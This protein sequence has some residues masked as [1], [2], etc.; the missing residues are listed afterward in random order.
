[1]PSETKSNSRPRISLVTAWVVFC[2]FCNVLGWVLSALHELNAGG[3]AVAFGLGLVAFAGWKWKTN[4]VFFRPNDFAKS[5]RRFRRPFPMAF[6]ILAALAIL[7]GVIYAP[8]NYD[9][10]AYRLPRVLHWLAEGHWHWIHTDFE[11]VNRRG[12]GIEWVCA[13][14]MALF[15]TDRP[16][17]LLN[18]ISFLLLPG[19]IF[20][21][22]TKLG[23]R[24]RTAWYW[25]WPLSCGY[26]FLLQ[27]GSIGNDLFTVP[28]VLAAMDYA[29]RSHQQKSLRALWLSIVAAALFTGVKANTVPL[30]LPWVIALA[31][32]WKMWWRKAYVTIPVC[33]VALVISFAPIGYF[34]AKYTGDWTGGVSEHLPSN[35]SS[36]P[37]KLAG[38]CVVLAING[39]TPPIAPFASW[40]NGHVAAKLEKTSLGKTI[41]E[42]FLVGN[43]FMMNEMDTEEVAGFGFGTYLLIAV[44]A[45]AV[46]LN[47]RN[48]AGVKMPRPTVF[49][50]VGTSISFL[51][52]M[53]TSFALSTPRLLAPYYLLLIFPLVFLADTGLLHKRWWKIVVLV[54]FALAALPLIAS[55]ARPLFPWRPALVLLEKAG[56]PP[57]FLQRAKTV[58]SVYSHR[59]DGFAPM[60]AALPPGLKVVGLVT[61][62]DP[63]AALWSPYGSRRVIHVCRDDSGAFLRSEGLSYVVVSSEKFSLDFAMP[64]EEWL[65]QVNGTRIDT[66]PLALRADKGS[67]DW[68]LVK[69]N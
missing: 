55:P 69:L 28:L 25:M 44:T 68:Y 51:V 17:F 67:V 10:L 26:C 62:D 8:S 24:G 4:A 22:F 40:W 53:A 16:L 11:R 2:V 29:L 57:R 20:N 15:K 46:L 60:K 64:F 66:V 9:A 19:L 37:A 3:Y 1:M 59:A 47:S 45:A 38:N 31:P 39:L 34:N 52:V 14:I 49:F 56:C 35:G 43:V 33:I 61:Y 18:A 41:G 63:E 13:P 7:G 23:V 27:A 65:K 58:Y 54:S 5:R 6:L 42:N 48:R 21:V 50:I 32:G 36:A 30:G 12:P